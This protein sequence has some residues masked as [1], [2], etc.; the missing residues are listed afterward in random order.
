MFGATFCSKKMQYREKNAIIGQHRSK[1]IIAPIEQVIIM[2]TSISIWPNLYRIRHGYFG[3]CVT[4]KTF[5]H[6]PFHSFYKEISW[7]MP[8]RSPV[9]L[10]G[11]P[12]QKVV[13]QSVARARRCSSWWN[14]PRIF[15]VRQ[16]CCGPLTSCNPV[17]PSTMKFHIVG[18]VPTSNSKVSVQSQVSYQA[19][20]SRTNW[21]LQGFLEGQSLWL[22]YFDSCHQFHD[23]MR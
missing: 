8:I 6:S 10:W 12:A 14:S 18:V 17:A 21:H 9:V 5:F 23:K 20:S 7:W 13:H 4:V 15:I 11:G 3:I 19:G 2:V 16:Q 1:N 22:N